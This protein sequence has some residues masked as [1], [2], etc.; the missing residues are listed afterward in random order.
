MP[1]VKHE[2]AIAMKPKQLVILGGTGFLGSYL[3]PRLAADGHRIVLL[4]RNRERHRELSVLPQVEIRST[5]VY[6]GN[7]LRRQFEGA[8]AVIHLIGILNP[9][10]RHTFQ[11][12]HVD[13]PR[14]VIAACQAAN[15][16][17]LHLM[18][19]LKAGQ[20]L[21][22]YLKTRG[23]AETVVRQSGL[24][25]TIY[26][27]S[28]MF[29]AGDGLVSRFA[30]LL[31]SMPVLPL[32]RAPSRLAP[33]YVGDVAEAIARCV[34]DDALSIDR[35]FELYGP[36]VLTLGEIVR[37][38]RDTAGLHTP[39]LPL[40]DSLGRL[41]ATF[42][43]LLPGKPFSRDN[44]LSLR[45]DSVGKQDGYATLGIHPQPLTP[46]LP[47]LLQGSIRQRR[48]DQ[49]RITYRAR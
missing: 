8:D 32:A 20:G 46:W 38:I 24:D 45:T 35:T 9:Q 27:S 41:Q 1:R 47:A 15:V 19:S 16:S 33:T 7:A 2:G 3:V 22:R 6:D 37:N 43:E 10:G 44:F 40:P 26:Q 14:R 5:D 25:W 12:T 36:E 30:K 23:E 17:R 42:A 49:A 29:G 4:S 11:E 48:L 28:V 18:S 31:R 34:A 13:L 21:S 39:I